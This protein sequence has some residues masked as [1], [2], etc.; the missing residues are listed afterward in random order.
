MNAS[1][2]AS[3]NKDSPYGSPTRAEERGRSPHRFPNRGPAQSPKTPFGVSSPLARVT[4]ETSSPIVTAGPTISEDPKENSKEEQQT[5]D[6]MEVA[7]PQISNKE[8]EGFPGKTEQKSDADKPEKEK[9][10]DD[11]GPSTVTDSEVLGEMKNVAI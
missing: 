10:S 9:E 1:G 4:E 5:E 6:L 11:A 8:N 3:S 7:T 2:K